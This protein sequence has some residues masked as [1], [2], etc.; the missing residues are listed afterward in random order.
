MGKIYA[1]TAYYVTGGRYTTAIDR[2]YW[3][4]SRP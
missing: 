1:L 3:K 2:L 4:R